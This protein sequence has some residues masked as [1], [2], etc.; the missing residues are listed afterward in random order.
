MVGRWVVGVWVFVSLICGATCARSD[1]DSIPDLGDVL[2]PGESDDDLPEVS[3]SR[4]AG[5]LTRADLLFLGGARDEFR[6]SVRLGSHIEVG[7]R[8][9]EESQTGYVVVSRLGVLKSLAI[10]NLRL[11][12]GERLLLGRGLIGYSL[13]TTG[14]VREGAVV[15][16]SLSRWSGR[17]GVA[18]DVGVGQWAARFVLFGEHSDDMEARM[19]LVSVGRR[20]ESLTAGA[21]VG[22]PLHE[23]VGERVGGRRA[24]VGSAY[25]LLR[26]KRF[27]ISGEVAGW[28]TLAPF[29]ALRVAARGR[30]GWALRCYRAPMFAATDPPLSGGE[31][32]ERWQQ[33]VTMSARYPIGQL[34]FRWTVYL[35][36][37]FSPDDYRRYRRAQASVA[38]KIVRG[39]WEAG[40][41]AI[42]DAMVSYVA[43]PLSERRST[44]KRQMRFRLKVRVHGGRSLSQSIQLD[45]RPGSHWGN[46]GL[47]ASVGLRATL[48]RLQAE[49][50]ATAYR[51]ADGQSMLLSRPGVGYFEWFSTAWGHGSDISVRL[52][53]AVTENLSLLAY[54]GQPWLR[55]QRI[56][57]GVRVVLR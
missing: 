51:M 1:N 34:R 26:K 39:E 3:H 5:R 20:S 36:S 18:A 57:I 14:P 12:I 25:L 19:F 40:V 52:L 2:S 38:G 47:G 16:P 13:S 30:D 35:V 31:P 15:A 11:R 17:P 41:I 42:D 46:D 23:R 4:R 22:I 54:Y 53:G 21:T 37:R 10:G 50:K 56:Y 6:G 33:G 32:L 45:Y 29:V 44:L 24:S 28:S 49:C 9:G 27:E 43:S 48:G 7:A 8:V 55:E